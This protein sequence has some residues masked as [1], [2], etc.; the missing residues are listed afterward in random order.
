MSKTAEKIE[1]NEIWEYVAQ[2]L[3]L[4]VKQKLLAHQLA[5]N[6]PVSGDLVE[7][8]FK[9]MF[10]RFLPKRFKVT[11]GHIVAAQPSGPPVVSPQVDLIIVDTMVPHSLVPFSSSSK[12]DFVP[13]EAVVGFFEVKGSVGM[14]K[15]EKSLY[16]ACVQLQNIYKSVVPAVP[17]SD[18][19][20]PGGIQFK[21]GKNITFS[22]GAYANPMAGILALSASGGFKQEKR[23][24]TLIKDLNSLSN[25]SPIDLIMISEGLIFAPLRKGEFFVDPAR[26]TKGA[27]AGETK[28]GICGI[29]FGN[30][31]SRGR[32]IG[33]ALGII[34]KYLQ[35][36]VGRS[37]DPV[38]YLLR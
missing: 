29:S 3:E 27:S 32:V 12:F 24:G 26:E 30:R 16:K 35:S 28:F 37:Y 6:I 23:V 34:L 11:S 13:I 14:G 33:M 31:P 18:G 15:G 21:G 9:E 2:E 10:R 8:A 5:K 1:W 38:K 4:A 17:T 22:G 20:F 36:V 25:Q 19:Y 7:N